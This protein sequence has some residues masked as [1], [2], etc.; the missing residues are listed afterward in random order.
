MIERATL[1]EPSYRTMPATIEALVRA[2]AVL[3]LDGKTHDA[4]L[5]M[6]HA[7]RL[8]AKHERAMAFEGLNDD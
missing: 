1:Y 5:V 8:K 3:T 2:A 4:I 6:Q 7:E